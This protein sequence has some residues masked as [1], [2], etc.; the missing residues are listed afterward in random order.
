MTRRQLI[1][2]NEKLRTKYEKKYF[3]PVKKAMK[4]HIS[5]FTTVLENQG[6]DAVRAKTS[7]ISIAEIGEPVMKMYTELGLE[8]ANTALK[9]LRMLPKVRTKKIN[10]GFNSEWTAAILE[11]FGAHLFDK[12]VLPVSDTT[13]N[14]IQLVLDEGIREGWSIERMVQEIERE[15]Y[16][17]GRVRRILRTESNRA[18]NYG[19]QLA[20]DKWE[21][22]AQKRWVAVH[23]NRTR[24]AHLSADGQTVDSNGFFTVGG[25]QMEFPGD[26][27]ASGKNT[28]N[29]R[30]F[31]EDVA[32][33]DGQGRLIPKED[34]PPVRIRG[35]LRRELQDILNELQ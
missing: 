3:K 1:R 12:L 7:D 35:R 25:E 22:K 21:Y 18:I 4:D 27:A 29:C 20:R 15:D 16:L 10:L 32:V 28:I 17:D 30:C 14:Y 8:K 26:P 9:A 24:H 31:S 13:R 5:S 2:Q 23:D 11:Y 6:V 33:R 34:K 19:G